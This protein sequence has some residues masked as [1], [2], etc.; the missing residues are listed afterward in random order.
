MKITLGILAYN[1]HEVIGRT[2]ASLLAQSVFSARALP[3]A[4]DM[5][6]YFVGPAPFMGAVKRLL[7]ELGVPAVERLGHRIVEMQVLQ[8]VA[9]DRVAQIEVLAAG[10]AGSRCEPVDGDHGEHAERHERHRPQVEHAER[11]GQA[12]VLA[13][14]S[15]ASVGSIYHHFG[16]K[17]G[18]AAALH[19]GKM[20]PSLPVLAEGLLV[21]PGFVDVHTHYDGQAVWDPYLTPSSCHGVTTTVFGNCGVGFAPL[22]PGAAPYLINLMEG[23]EDIPGTVLAVTLA[24]GAPWAPLAGL[25][26][27]PPA[28]RDCW[29]PW[30]AATARH[31]AW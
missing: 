12:D 6:A 13:E 11:A 3:Q 29:R 18:I 19:I 10:V 4:R 27:T 15:G 21:T 23:V 1:E 5:D 7:G 8:H 14:E 22:R 24:A 20:P 2:I 9:V 16:T 28:W 26:R 17:E 31:C 25:A 30:A